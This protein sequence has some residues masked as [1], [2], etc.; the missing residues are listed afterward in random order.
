M[1][2]AKAM[3]VKL[4]D[5]GKNYAGKGKAVNEVGDDELTEEQKLTKANDLAAYNSYLTQTK[6]KDSALDMYAQSQ[7]R[8]Q[9]DAYMDNELLKKYLPQTLNASG[10]GNLGVSQSAYI[11]AD[12]NYANRVGNVNRSADKLRNA[13][14]DDYR[15]A[16]TDIENNLTEKNALLLDNYKRENEAKA[17]ARAEQ[18]YADAGA[19]L[20]KYLADYGM[21]GLIADDEKSKLYEA[22]EQY[23][24]ALGGVES[25]KYK[26]L[27]KATDY[28]I[29][30]TNTK[31]YTEA[32][33][34]HLE[35]DVKGDDFDVTINGKK[36]KDIELGSKAGENIVNAAKNVPKQSL[37]IYGQDVYIKTD[38][39]VYR[40]GGNGTAGADNAGAGAGATSYKNLQKALRDAGAILG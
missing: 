2:E 1:R 38:K 9:Q 19:W 6:N 16:V 3:S 40:V 12:N 5:Y 24:D 7:K 35:D 39:G 13:T 27:K 31:R 23:K 26:E 33:V 11:Q 22:L 14:L 30:R 4:D 20:D 32:T 17:A 10:L 29:D 18:A 28:E 21:D 37:F 8:Q 15:N 34:G 36:Y 25:D